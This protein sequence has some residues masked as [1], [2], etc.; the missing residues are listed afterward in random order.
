MNL[1][2][3]NQYVTF[4]TGVDTTVY[5]S[6][7]RINSLNRW[8]NKIWTMILASEDS[9][10]IDDP[11]QV[12]YPSISTP[13]Q[14]NQRDYTLPQSLGMLKIVRVDVS[15]NGTTPNR[16]NP[17]DDQVFRFGLNGTQTQTDQNFTQANPFY[18]VKSNALFLYPAPTST[19]GTVRIEYQRDPIEFAVTDLSTT[20]LPP[21]DTPW[22]IMLA[23][24]M[25]F[26]WASAKKLDDLKQDVMIELQDYETR[27]RQQ[28]S[29]KVDDEVW[30]LQNIG[31]NDGS[32]LLGYPQNP[33]T[34]F[35]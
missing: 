8:L 5:F 22:H 9:W 1:T 26:D 31:I 3:I 7:D 2:T 15:Y 29:K 23:F 11:N 33:V 18:D 30:I 34:N 13:L 24:G 6:Q 19:S 35:N 14:A 12:N 28:Y 27:L 17:I 21:L 32:S 20:K 25:I 10:D 4:R 16:A